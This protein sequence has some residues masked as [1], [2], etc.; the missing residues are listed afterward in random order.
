MRA[1]RQRKKARTAATAIPAE[2]RAQPR[3]ARSEGKRPVQPGGK[4][5]SS[6]NARTWST[7]ES[8]QQGAG[9]GFG[10]M[11][12]GGIGCIDIDHCINPDGTLTE[13]AQRILASNPG[14][15]VERSVSGT[16]LHVFGLLPEQPGRKHDGFEV[17]STGRFIRCTGE[18]FQH[19]Q[20]VE[21]HV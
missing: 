6:T 2:L 7:F 16:G 11:L 5:A 13:T 12:G 19:G 4:S 17:Y 8:V 10:F 15:W 14:A 21:L 18:V 20:L 3:W 9:D 1:Y